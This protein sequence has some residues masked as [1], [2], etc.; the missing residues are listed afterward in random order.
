VI[1]Y[2]GAL[3]AGNVTIISP[4]SSAVIPDPAVEAM[5]APYRTQLIAA[6]DGVIG[7]A[8]DI[9]P[10][11]NNIE[12]LMEVAI[13]NLIADAYRVHYGTQIALMNGGGI[14]A[15][16]PSSYLPT[17]TTLRRTTPG[18]APG[19]PYDLVTGDVY[20]VLPFG[21]AVV[22]RPVTG[23]QLWAA[24]ENA[25]SALPGAAGKFAQISGFRFTYT[26]SQ[27]PGSRV[28]SVTLDDNTPILPDN[29]SYSL[30]TIDF[31]NAGGDGY[32]MFQDGQGTTLDVAADVVV[33]Y[34]E[35]LGTITPVIEGRIVEVP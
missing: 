27:P 12:R 1:P 16:L 29:T 24:L 17:D 33:E 13:G 32:T 10:R 3:V 25:V 23:S 7:V 34:I 18:Y 31:L 8:T 35:M 6:L 11:G 15:P 19:P 26:L 21:N 9:F 5:L 28:V 20:T 4:V 22:T 2:T 14:R 30:A